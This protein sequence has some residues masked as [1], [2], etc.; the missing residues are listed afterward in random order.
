MYVDLPK[1]MYYSIGEV[2]D[3]FDVNASLIRFW[4]KEFDIIKP[5]KNA[6]GNRKF[7]PEDIK[8][9]ELIYHLVKERG[10]TLEGAKIHLKEQ[11]QEA[12][13]SFDIIR[14]LE[15]IKGQLL[16]IKEQL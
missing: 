8:N 16:K 1:K 13:D 11:K 14:K 7:T 4:E 9:L 2:A 3:A 5:K 10:F 6:K 15:S 12:L